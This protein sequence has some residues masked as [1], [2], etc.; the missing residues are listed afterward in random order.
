MVPLT[1]LPA[2]VVDRTE[3]FVVPLTTLSAWVV[4]RT[5]SVNECGLLI[6]RGVPKVVPAVVVV[7][8][9][10]G[11][12]VLRRICADEDEDLRRRG[13]PLTPPPT[14]PLLLLPIPTTVTAEVAG[15]AIT[16][17]L[18]ALTDAT[19]EFAVC[20]CREEIKGTGINTDKP[21]VGICSECRRRGIDECDAMS[22]V[23]RDGDGDDNIPSR[24]TGGN[25]VGGRLIS[26]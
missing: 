2:W 21:D 13:A 1:T 16:R 7:A 10:V 17:S 12:A 9:V 20:A 26:C 4:D 11:D 3:P 25:R 22:G 15:L 23:D 5:E 18:F 6:N 24:T 8:V 19:M 14:P